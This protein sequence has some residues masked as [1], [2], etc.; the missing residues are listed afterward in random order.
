MRRCSPSPSLSISIARKAVAST[1]MSSF[2]TGV[3][4][5]WRP[6][7]SRRRT[8][9]NSRTIAGRRIG[10]PSWYQVPSRAMRMPEWPQR[11]GFHWSTGGRRR[12]SIS[13]WSSARLMP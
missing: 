1:S 2:S 11:S 7:G 9:E 12:S 6:S 8:V 3:T 5:T 10:W 13:A 4:S